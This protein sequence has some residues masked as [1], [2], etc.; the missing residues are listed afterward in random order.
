MPGPAAPEEM[1]VPSA[2]LARPTA[3]L[4]LCVPSTFLRERLLRYLREQFRTCSVSTPRDA[5]EALEYAGTLRPAV[6]VIDIDAVPPDGWVLLGALRTAAPLLPLVA[7]STYHADPLRPRARASGA[8]ACLSPQT[9][10]G[11]LA[12]VIDPLLERAR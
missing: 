2:P 9:L 1:P 10:D 6:A 8:A 5:V 4:L 7:L 3:T 11:E 12:A